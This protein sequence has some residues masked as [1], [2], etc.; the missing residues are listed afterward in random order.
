M[1][2]FIDLVDSTGVSCGTMEK[3]DAHRAGARHRAISVMLRDSHGR[4]LLQRRSA[5]KYHAGGLWSNTCCGHP[6]P[7]ESP[8]TAARRRLRF[9]M[10]IECELL[11]AGTFSYQCPVTDDLVE[12]EW[13]HLFVGQHDGRITPEPNEVSQYRWQRAR[14]LDA[15]RLSMRGDAFTPWFRIYLR[16][17]PRFVQAKEPLRA[18]T[19]ST[20][21]ESRADRLDFRLSPSI[22]NGRTWR[23]FSK[24]K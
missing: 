24:L 6:F 19:I 23:S 11:P 22:F 1:T 2:E 14:S 3:L 10:G 21:L 5:S 13:V 17:L 12:N 16:E 8:L 9:E 18:R 15:S 20:H 7:G 4:V